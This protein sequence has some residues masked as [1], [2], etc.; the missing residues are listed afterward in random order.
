[1]GEFRALLWVS[2]PIFALA[3]AGCVAPEVRPATG[4][5]AVPSMSVDRLVPVAFPSEW[6]RGDRR[7]SEVTS[8]NDLGHYYI[9]TS[10]TDVRAH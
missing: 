1:M 6:R 4:P 8:A 10:G 5:S 9:I 2:R 7:R 3:G